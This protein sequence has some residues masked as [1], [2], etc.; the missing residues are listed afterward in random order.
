[1]TRR[2]LLS[3]TLALGAALLAPQAPLGGPIAAA[4]AAAAAEQ[5][6]A[7]EPGRTEREKAR[8]VA[9]L[10]ERYHYR[11]SPE[12]YSVAEEAAEAYLKRLDHGR[13]FLLAED[14]ERFRERVAEADGDI[15]AI[16][17]AA[18]DLY[19]V[20]QERVTEQIRYA[21]ELLDQPLEFDREGRYEPDRREAEWADSEQAL[22]ALWRRRVTHDALTLELAG[23]EPEKIRENLGH[24][25]RTLQERALEVSR[26]DVMA[27]YLSAWASAYDPHSSYFSPRRSK[28]FDM[29]MSLQLEGIGAKLTMEQDYTKIVELIPGGPAK[30]SG[31]LEEGERIIGVADGEDGRMKNIVGW[32]LQD[33][34]QLIRGPKESVV[35]LKVL[36]PAGASESS[37]RVVRLVR[38]KIDLEDQAARKEVIEL[39]AEGAD[40]E[41]Q[42]IGVIE[43]PRFYRDFSA[44]QAGKEDYRSTT[45]DVKRLLE[46]LEG[47]EIDGLVIDLRDNS[48]GA[49]RE[50]TGLT[51]LFTGEGP[52]VQVR[53]HTG[54]TEQV[55]G[56]HPPAYDGPLGVL[57]NRRSA[58]ASEIFAAAI[59]DYN[60]GVVIG[61]QTFGKGTV[62]QMINLGNYAIPGEEKSGQLKLTIAQFYRVNGESTQLA[63]V[64]PHI[65]LPSLLDHDELGERAAENPLPATRIEPVGVEQRTGIDAGLI[66]TLRERHEQRVAQE[67]AFEAFTAELEYKRR[68]REETATPLDKERRQA[69]KAQREERLLALHNHRREVHGLEPVASYEEIDEEP[70]PDLLLR[71]SAAVVGDLAEL[72][73]RQEPERELA[74]EGGVS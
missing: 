21:L 69:E 38:N 7:L 26:D 64:R 13:F 55:G 4:S 37:P 20:Y 14:A 8:V 12:D 2:L 35:R 58:S 30:S 72:L 33:I 54:Q 52:A 57:V 17:E 67:A 40:A 65:S 63:G 1:M 53:N 34:V 24:R 6:A 3:L 44:A 28:E 49:L 62:Q 36:P 39:P 25:Y 10:L 16:V 56:G 42:R 45:R 60:R 43:I 74:R 68:L 41:Q 11:G 29:Q 19:T 5:E 31:K 61:D 18:F 27:D 66:E 70:L 15:D 51:D 71:E 59:K 46:E 32:R 9:D 47:Q 50:A 73:G 23:R 48:G 22:D